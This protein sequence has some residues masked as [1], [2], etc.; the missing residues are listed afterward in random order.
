MPPPIKNGVI[1]WRMRKYPS[2]SQA[3]KAFQDAGVRFP[4][5][6][7]HRGRGRDLGVGMQQCKP[8]QWTFGTDRDAP[9]ELIV[10]SI[11]CTDAE[12]TRAGQLVLGANI[13][14]CVRV[15]ESCAAG[16]DLNECSARRLTEPVTAA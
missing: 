15:A 1:V 12:D 10:A 16:W 3:S 7:R 8:R 14:G 6:S 2:T 4:P 13:A 5:A 9:G 11:P